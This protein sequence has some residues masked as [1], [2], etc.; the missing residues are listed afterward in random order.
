MTLFV[1][2]SWQ[3]WDGKTL[4]RLTDGSVWEQAEYHY[5]YH[6]AY[7]PA[8]TVTGNLMLVVGMQR[9]VPVRRLR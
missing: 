8:V 9:A 5:E 6:Y 2:G 3:G 4:V 1:D 7:R